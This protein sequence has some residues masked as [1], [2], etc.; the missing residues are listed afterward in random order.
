MPC[1]FADTD[2]E[3]QQLTKLKSKQSSGQVFILFWSSLQLLVQLDNCKYGSLYNYVHEHLVIYS[4]LFS[5][6]QLF[7]FEAMR[8]KLYP[9]WMISTKSVLLFRSQSSMT[10]E[11]KYGWLFWG[12]EGQF[13]KFLKATLILCNKKEQQIYS[14][15]LN[16]NL[17]KLAITSLPGSSSQ[18]SIKQVQAFEE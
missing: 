15:Q 13:S 3:H 11:I 12:T 17:A 16:D 7:I 9:V 2:V 10:W 18:Q 14:I 8:Q 1:V 4:P 5:N 6:H